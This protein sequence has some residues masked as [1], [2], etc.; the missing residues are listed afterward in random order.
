MKTARRPEYSWVNDAREN[1][2]WFLLFTFAV[3]VTTGALADGVQIWLGRSWTIAIGLVLVVGL[4]YVLG[5]VQ[6]VDSWLRRRAGQAITT[7]VP[8]PDQDMHQCRGLITAVS[9]GEGTSHRDAA[10]FHLGV[11]PSGDQRL[12]HVWLLHT[13]ESEEKARSEQGYLTQRGVEVT[14]RRV[15]NSYDAQQ[16]FQAI[17][18][19]IDEAHT[20]KRLSADDIA[21]DITAGPRN[22]AVGA[23]VACTGG[24]A[25][26]EYMQGVYR[27]GKRDTKGVS[28]AL[29]ITVNAHPVKTEVADAE[30]AA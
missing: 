23:V 1:P 25:L 18:D 27:D 19:F 30:P 3:A 26:L 13:R 17:S 11:L 24:R 8:T 7:D 21:V 9:A 6:L 20:E 2:W 16:F 29:K 22:L 15:D 14:M 5:I 12:Q 4:G 10:N 28:K